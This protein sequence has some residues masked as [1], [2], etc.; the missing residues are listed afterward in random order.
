LKS[1]EKFFT[2]EELKKADAA[3]FCGTGAEVIGFESLDDYR[4][5]LNWN[6]RVSR[7]IQIAYM[8]LVKEDFCEPQ[9]HEDTKKHKEITV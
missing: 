1:E 7:K 5:P 6:D 3:F 8:K 4:I 9:R 2:V